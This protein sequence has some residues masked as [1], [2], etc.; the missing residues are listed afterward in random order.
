MKELAMEYVHKG[1][2][3]HFVAKFAG[4]TENELAEALE[5]EAIMLNQIEDDYK[6]N[7]L[8]K[9]HKAIQDFLDEFPQ[10]EKRKIRMSI[11]LEHMQK[12]KK[13]KEVEGLRKL[14]LEYQILMGLRQ[15]IEPEQ[16]LRAR[17][18]PITELIKNRIGMALCPFHA[19][20]TASMDIRKNFYH[21]YGCG[22]QG[23]VIDFVMKTQGLSFKEAIT[24]LT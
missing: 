3:S 20:K 1:M 24:K 18:Y 5:D 13:N 11:L 23:D 2:K 14:V 9:V 21:C 19:D 4:I 10:D 7:E 12:A 6:K 15:N 17:E 22:A 8:P 16:V